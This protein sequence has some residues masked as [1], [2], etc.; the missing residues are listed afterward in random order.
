MTKSRKKILLFTEFSK[1]IGKGHYYRSLQIKKNYQGN[2]SVKLNLI[3]AEIIF[4]L[5]LKKKNLLW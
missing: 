5:K 4:I 3:K 2:I 1:K